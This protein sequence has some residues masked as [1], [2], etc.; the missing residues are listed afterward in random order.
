ML[1]ETHTRPTWSASRALSTTLLLVRI[2]SCVQTTCRLVVSNFTISCTYEAKHNSAK[3]QKTTRVTRT[4]RGILS[5]DDFVR[6]EP[7]VEVQVTI[8]VGRHSAVVWVGRVQADAIVGLG[9]RGSDEH[10]HARTHF[11]DVE[12]STYCHR[13]C[14][15]R[16]SFDRHRCRAE[17]AREKSVIGVL[18]LELKKANRAHRHEKDVVVSFRRQTPLWDRPVEDTSLSR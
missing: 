11:R 10:S 4:Y 8:E 7:D 2:S 15:S 18:F 12:A 17:D 6:G 3:S 14:G 9:Y 16:R 13:R 5:T 1:V